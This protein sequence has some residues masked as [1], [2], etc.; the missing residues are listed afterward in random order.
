MASPLFQDIAGLGL[1]QAALKGPGALTAALQALAQ[2]LVRRT[3]ADR[4]SLAFGDGHGGAFGPFEARTRGTGDRLWNRQIG[5]APEILGTLQ[6][7]FAPGRPQPEAEL[8]GDL[9][10]VLELATGVVRLVLA[11]RDGGL[12][13]QTFLA[14]LSHE[15]RTPLNGI[16]GFS[17]LLSTTALEANQRAMVQTIVDS[18]QRLLDTFDNLLDLSRFESGDAEIEHAAFSPRTVFDTTLGRLRPAAVAKGLSWTAEAVPGVP[19]IL[20]GDPVRLGQA[21]GHVL[22]NAVKFTATGGVTVRLEAR[23]LGGGQVDLVLEVHDTGIGYNPG[24]D[25]TDFSPFRQE[26]GSPTRRFGGTGLGLALCHRIVNLMHGQVTIQGQ[27][28]VGTRVVV[29]VRCHASDFK[30]EPLSKEPA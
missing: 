14:N 19:E 21:W 16:L 18:G 7:W 10:L 29:Q 8:A 23:P 1:L 6:L 12:A 15:L 25:Q 30:N 20:V 27:K 11:R 13:Q 17:H 28:G 5:T 3:G 9:Q 22:A 26:D 2:A 24:P 4:A